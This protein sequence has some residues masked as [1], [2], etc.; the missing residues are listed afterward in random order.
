[1]VETLKAPDEAEAFEGMVLKKRGTGVI[2]SESFPTK[3]FQICK[4]SSR[5]F[6][7][8]GTFYE[9]FGIKF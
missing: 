7:V 5:D 2:F 4:K 9:K 6:S 1:M 8:L 3:T